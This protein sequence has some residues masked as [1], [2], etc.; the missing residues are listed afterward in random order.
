MKK[1]FLIGAISV[2]GIMVS[3]CAT[4][5]TGTSAA[6]SL[7]GSDMQNRVQ[8][9]VVEKSADNFLGNIGLPG[10]KKEKTTEEKLIDVATGKSSAE[11]LATDIVA[12]KLADQAMKKIY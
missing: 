8:Q 3:G 10:L 9:K 11:D 6:A 12:D 2:T 4:G 5:A 1:I 7:A